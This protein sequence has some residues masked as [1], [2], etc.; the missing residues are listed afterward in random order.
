MRDKSAKVVGD[1][2][3]RFADTQ[4]GGFL[5]D[6]PTAENRSFAVEVGEGEEL[7]VDISFGTILSI[8]LLEEIPP[9]SDLNVGA[10]AGKNG[11]A[12]IVCQAALFGVSR[13]K[14]GAVGIKLP[15][16]RKDGLVGKDH[17][18]GGFNPVGIV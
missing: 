3:I 5:P 17:F 12:D 11:F 14:P 2:V 9:T 18:P 16:Y 6:D 8:G 10:F 13:Q 7:L 4:P 15:K 1:Q